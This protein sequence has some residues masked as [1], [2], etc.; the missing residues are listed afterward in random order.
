M[1]PQVV[2]FIIII[3]AIS[4]TIG[5]IVGWL[6]ASLRA[7]KNTKTVDGVLKDDAPADHQTVLRLW[8]SLKD[9]SLLVELRGR[10]LG[11]ADGLSLNERQAL[12]DLIKRLRQW[13]G[14]PDDPPLSA[15]PVPSSM[16]LPSGMAVPTGP[17]GPVVT[18]NEELRPN[19]IGSMTTVLADVISQ[20]PVARRDAPM[21]MVKQ[22]DEILQAKLVGTP[23]E[24]QKI[25]LVEDPRKGVIVWVGAQ[26]YEGVGAVPEGEI[27]NLLRASVQEWEQRQEKTSRRP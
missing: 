9:G 6:L 20:P 1:A 12:V 5:Y 24:R 16:G 10:K 8:T 17:I 26:M 25:S 13:M 11:T 18:T 4:L 3:A 15:V 21:S 7:D 22:I 27:K 2:T 19:L 23:Y 14:I